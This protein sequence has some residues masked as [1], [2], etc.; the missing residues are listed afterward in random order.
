MA[1]MGLIAGIYLTDKKYP[2]KNN[3]HL[4]LDLSIC[5][6]LRMCS[7]MIIVSYVIMEKKAN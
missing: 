2:F 5:Q 3:F 1:D 4:L 7:M 6:L